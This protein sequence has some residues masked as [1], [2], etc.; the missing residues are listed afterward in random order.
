MK[1]NI[2]I[3]IEDA[4]RIF[5]LLEELHDFLHQPM[6][7]SSREDVETWLIK[8]GVYPELRHVYYKIVGN[9]FPVSDDTSIVE[10]PPGS[11]RRFGEE[12]K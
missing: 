11:T 4:W 2:T 8:K 5:E 9:W 7:Y 3:P 12:D 10:A 1:K 6:N